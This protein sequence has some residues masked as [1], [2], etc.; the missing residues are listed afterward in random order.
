VE[1]GFGFSARSPLVAQRSRPDA[2]PGRARP[3][4]RGTEDLEAGTL[5]R[6]PIHRWAGQP[7]TIDFVVGFSRRAPP[8]SCGD[9][10]VAGRGA[11]GA[12]DVLNYT[13]AP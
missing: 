3:G 7:T 5:V 10:A 2:D 12:V 6:L 8:G 13:P 9:L 4:G 11:R 1:P